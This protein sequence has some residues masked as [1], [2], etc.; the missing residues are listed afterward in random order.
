MIDI[1][2]VEA[3]ASKFNRASEL[4]DKSIR[5]CR[6]SIEN[7]RKNESKSTMDFIKRIEQEIDRLTNCSKSCKS[8]ANTM[9]NEARRIREEQERALRNSVPN[10]NNYDGHS[11]VEALAQSGSE[12]SY[13]YRKDLAQN[14]GVNNYVGTADQNIDLINKMKDIH[15]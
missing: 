12:F 4:I 11:V 13:D 2:N 1:G 14:L 10:I 6:S 3:R 15:K 8:I 9:I 5:F 7:L